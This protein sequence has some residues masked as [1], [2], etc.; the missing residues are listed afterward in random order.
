MFKTLVPLKFSQHADFRF[1]LNPD[2]SF[3]RAELVAPIV[4][5]EIADVAREYPII[6]PT[7]SALPVALMGVQSGSNAYV[8]PTGGWRAA[9]IPAHI[10]HYPLA[11]TR[12]PVAPA[13][14]VPMADRDA[15]FAI[16]IDV[17]SPMI[18]RLEGEPVFEDD[19]T[20]S[21]LSQ[22]KTQLLNTLQLRAG[23]TQRLVQAIDAAGLL[24]ERAIR[25]KVEGKEDRQVTGLRVIDEAALNKLEDIT[26][27]KL[28]ASGAL[29]LIYAS[30]LSWANFRQGPI[31]KSHMLPKQESNAE[32]IEELL[33]FN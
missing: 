10:R 29:P 21:A 17:D 1:Q 24:I 14:E 8:S 15:R 31:G 33:R 27:N 13:D 16:L 7:G 5:D 11:I 22:Q 32:K 12:I 9:Y 20:L 18:S 6:F 30:L 4:I 3:A 23:V 19:G 25:I 2:Y 28:R 26:F